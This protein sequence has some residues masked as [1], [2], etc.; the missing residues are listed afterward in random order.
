MCYF[1]G[2]VSRKR[3]KRL[4][5]VVIAGMALLLIPIISPASSFFTSCNH[6]ENTIFQVSTIGALV[7]GSYDSDYSYRD[8]MCHGNFGVGTFSNLNGEMIALDNDF[9]QMGVK[10]NLTTVNPS[11]QAPF[12][13]VIDFQPKFFENIEDVANY[14]ALGIALS[15]YLSNHNIP[16]AI[17]MDGTFK[18]IKFRNFPAQKKPYPPLSE[19]VS[20]QTVVTLHNVQG[21]LV[22]FWFP[23]YW[24]GIAT[25]GFHFYF[26]NTAHTIGGHVLEVSV[27]DGRA[28]IEPVQNM[29]FYLPNT[30]S[31]E[32]VNTSAAN[33]ASAIAK[34]EG[35][36]E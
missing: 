34:T 24:E 9:Y 15:R 26:I 3:N 36:H 32:T 20:K 27:A 19:V 30:T 23:H 31:F 25:P 35:G 29:Q 1:Y 4:K 2:N 22:G 17:R 5:N 33:M 11:D 8:V 13:E 6:A 10:G 18:T 21:T 12:A 7:L 14:H 28:S 16:Y